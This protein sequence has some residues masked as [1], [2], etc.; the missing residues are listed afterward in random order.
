MVAVAGKKKRWWKV[1]IGLAIALVLV[2]A[3]LPTALGARWIYQP[4]VNRL[5]ADDFQLHIASVRLRW[6]SP[7]RLSGVEIRQANG[8]TLIS[9]PEV[10][11]DRSLLGY[12]L[13]GRRLGRIVI[14]RPVLDVELLK[15]SSNLQRFVSAVDNA[16]APPAGAERERP[17]IDVQVVIHSLSATVKRQSDSSPL[18]VVPPLDLDLTYRASGSASGAPTHLSVAP[19]TLLDRVKLTPELVALGLDRALPLLAKSAWFDGSVSLRIASLDLPLERLADAAGEMELT[20]HEVRS[21]PSDPKILRLLDVIAT[22]R[23]RPPQHELVFVDGSQVAVTLADGRVTHHGLKMGLP[24]VDPRLQLATSGS[25]GLVDRS[26]DLMLDVPVPLEQLARRETVQQL[27]V[28]TLR[29]P[30]GGT[31]DDPQVHWEA[32]RGDAAD[33]LGAIGARVGEDSPAAAAVLDA[34]GGLTEGKADQAISSA[35]DLIDQLRK[36]RQQ[37]AEKKAAEQAAGSEPESEADSK[38]DSETTPRPP[39][40]RDRLR[41]L[42]RGPKP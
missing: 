5:A 23:K 1:A 15:D 32:L 9:I 8:P 12:L 35:V 14:E 3:L 40:M 28:P 20:L 4:L 24:K 36:R 27:G 34:L 10:T 25:V 26:L 39:R 16:V 18:V 31:L 29:L 37:A 41:D 11:T 42:F 17:A 19:T 33:L 21:G 2:I 13:G 38:S 22:L 6:L 30:I 7:V